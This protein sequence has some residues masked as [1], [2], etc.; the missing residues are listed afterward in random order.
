MKICDAGLINSLTE[1]LNRL[2][3]SSDHLDICQA[4]V[5]AKIVYP[6]RWK[7]TVCS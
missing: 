3:N 5:L 1:D 6:K 2:L 4:S 7:L